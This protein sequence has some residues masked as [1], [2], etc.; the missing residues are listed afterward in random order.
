[1]KLELCMPYFPSFYNPGEG[2]RRGVNETLVIVSDAAGRHEATA[3][4]YSSR[5]S[6]IVIPSPIA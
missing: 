3:P 1:M 6:L 4:A 2:F 5:P